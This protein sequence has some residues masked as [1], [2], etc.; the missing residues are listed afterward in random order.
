MRDAGGGQAATCLDHQP[1]LEEVHDMD[2]LRELPAGTRTR[3]AGGACA[4]RR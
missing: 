1:G 3:D 2:L 4:R